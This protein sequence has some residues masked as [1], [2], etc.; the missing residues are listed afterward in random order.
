MSKYSNVILFNFIS[1]LCWLQQ[2]SYTPCTEKKQLGNTELRGTPWTLE[3]RPQQAT[4]VV[5]S[6][7]PSS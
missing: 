6:I 5:T 7:N 3:T 2:I 1:V 4:C